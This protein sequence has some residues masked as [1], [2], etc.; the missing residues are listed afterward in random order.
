MDD[1]YT[2]EVIAL[3]G[4]TDADALDEIDCGK[5]LQEIEDFAEVGDDEDIE[6]DN[7]WE[8]V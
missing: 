4:D 6:G 3:T 5:L 2:E 7:D 1:D 8:S